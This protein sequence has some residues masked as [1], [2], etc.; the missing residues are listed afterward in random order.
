MRYRQ[1]FTTSGRGAPCSSA[2]PGL[3]GKVAV[4]VGAAPGGIGGAT[5][6]AMADAGA[7]VVVIDVR[8]EI[9]AEI[10]ADIEAAGGRALGLTADARSSEEVRTAFDAA[11]THFGVPSCLINVAGG[12]R[13]ETWARIEE[14]DDE[15]MSAAIE[16]NFGAMFRCCR[17]GA[18]RTM[19]AGIAGSIV[20]FAS[21]SGIH[22]APYHA[23][24]GAA[25]AAVI[26]MTQSMANEWGDH[27]IRLNAVT[28]GRVVTART[29]AMIGL[30]W[31]PDSFNLVPGDF[32]AS[33]I[34]AVVLLLA[35][36][37]ASSITGQTIA[38]DRGV[39]ARHPMGG[40]DLSA[41]RITPPQV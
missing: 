36:D 41:P 16:L 12:T 26:A 40:R 23:T 17:E 10:V 39:T 29:K 30:G 14:T 8:D 2:Y 13:P 38:V 35:P 19:E 1:R 22:G 33:D 7:D 9:G 34:A 32:P 28:P 5:A 21:V 3:D 6:L 4:V 20:N 27:R 15:V 24:Y 37:L 18:R 25:K 31:K 11:A